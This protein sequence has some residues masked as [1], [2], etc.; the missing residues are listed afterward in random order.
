[1]IAIKALA[2]SVGKNQLKI[3]P[4]DINCTNLDLSKNK[5]K[6]YIRDLI[7]RDESGAILFQKC[8]TLNFLDRWIILSHG[9]K[10]HLEGDDNGKL[11]VEE[12]KRGVKKIFVLLNS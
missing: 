1:M 2:F 6:Y 3:L 9:G 8:R 10:C 5:V 4:L 12:G 7:I 11:I